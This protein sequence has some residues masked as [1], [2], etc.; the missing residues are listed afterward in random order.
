MIF[1]TTSK[2]LNILLIRG[3]TATLKSAELILEDRFKDK[4]YNI[5]S[6]HHVD[7]L[8]SNVTDSNIDIGAIRFSN[9]FIPNPRGK[10]VAKELKEEFKV[11]VDHCTPS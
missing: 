9:L 3:D 2:G 7:L 11:R 1:I 4:T 10:Q 5:L 8:T 6:V